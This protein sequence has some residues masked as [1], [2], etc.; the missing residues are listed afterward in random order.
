MSGDVELKI[1]KDVV[2]PILEAKIKAALLDSM[3]V[4]YERIVKDMLDHYLN[5]E[6]DS[7]GKPST[8][9]RDSDRRRID[10]LLNNCIEEAVKTAIVEH[11]QKDKE[12]LA[13]EV[14][15]YFQSKKGN[16]ALAR[17]VSDGMIDSMK[18]IWQFNVGVTVGRD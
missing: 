9:R 11:V 7:T 6:V 16:N 1:S 17:A 3:G 2:K 13:V 5:E 14:Q 15:K 4:S 12:R 8:Y 18:N 10:F